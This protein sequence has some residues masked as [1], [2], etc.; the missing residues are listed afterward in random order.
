MNIENRRCCSLGRFAASPAFGTIKKVILSHVGRL[1]ISNQGIDH[2]MIED[3]K[4]AVIG[5]FAK[6]RREIKDAT[7]FQDAFQFG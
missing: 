2:L 5:R 7:R 3:L 6:R 4:P 1:K